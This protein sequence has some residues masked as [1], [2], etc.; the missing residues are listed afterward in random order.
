M[1]TYETI[2]ILDPK[3]LEDGGEAFSKAAGAQV[4]AL[5]GK[6]QKSVSLGRRQFARPIG[7]HKAGVYWDLVVDLANE[8]VAVLKDRY[9]LNST[10][11]RLEVFDYVEASD[12]T[13]LNTTPRID[14]GSYG[15]MGDRGDRGDRGGG[16]G[17][18]DRDR[19]RDGDRGRG[20]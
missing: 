14:F 9:R 18:R 2:F 13:K 20:R 17:G 8:S 5:G 1:R 6:V 7:K 15:D 10:V 3:K 4:E 12:P 16:G 19:D 11:L